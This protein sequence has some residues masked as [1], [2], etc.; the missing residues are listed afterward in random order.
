MEYLH[1]FRVEK[2]V[3]AQRS[4]VVELPRVKRRDSTALQCVLERMRRPHR[5]AANM[6]VL[7]TSRESFFCGDGLDNMTFDIWSMDIWPGLISLFF[8]FY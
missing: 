4:E 8:C 6:E 2:K 7:L 1:L 3:F 5:E